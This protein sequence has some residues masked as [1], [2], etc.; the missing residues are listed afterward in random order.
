MAAG[1]RRVAG[2]AGAYL[3]LL[4]RFRAGQGGRTQEL[5]AALQAN[6]TQA[7]QRLAHTLKGVAGTL[8]AEG[9]QHA[10][11]ALEEA[12]R[13]GAAPAPAEVLVDA[14]DAVLGPLLDALA[15]AL[16][17][18]TAVVPAH[19]AGPEALRRLSGDIAALLARSDIEARELI[20]QNAPLLAAAYGMEFA[21]LR[22]AVE[23]FD[24]ES[25]ARTLATAAAARGIDLPA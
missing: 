6:D 18:E 17:Q 10:A 4:R 16:P 21:R 5:R 25:A 15:Q 9:V 3:S 22:D 19:D 24:F 14:L 1:L 20:L 2:N 8:G 11:A 12:L 7:A 23:V 13:D